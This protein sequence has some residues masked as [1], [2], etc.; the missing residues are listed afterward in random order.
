LSD[1]GICTTLNGNPIKMTFS[2]VNDKI[3]DLKRNIGA[4]CDERFDVKRITGSGNHH[5]KKMW[6]NVGDVTSQIETA[7]TM[8][9]SI[10]G[11]RDFVSVR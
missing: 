5:Q 11:W 10:N 9:V 1:A 2:D 7:G 6:L 3:K 4:S 8:K